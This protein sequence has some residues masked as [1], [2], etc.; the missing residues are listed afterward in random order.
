MC[1]QYSHDNRTLKR[2]VNILGYPIK[3]RYVC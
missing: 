1:V 3:M 2:N